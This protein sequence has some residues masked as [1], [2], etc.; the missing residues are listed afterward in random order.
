MVLLA[1]REDS[2]CLF[3]LLNINE[4][5]MVQFSSQI[6]PFL[7]ASCLKEEDDGDDENAQL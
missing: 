7:I 3:K 1:V 2:L 4:P 6:N 5:V